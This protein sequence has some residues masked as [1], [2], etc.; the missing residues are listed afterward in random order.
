M[1]TTH[2]TALLALGLTGCLDGKPDTGADSG[3]QTTD[4]GSGD[5]SDDGEGDESGDPISGVAGSLSSTWQ[6]EWD[7]R[8]SQCAGC[9]LPWDAELT[10]NFR[11]TCDFGEDTSGVLELTAGTVYFNGDYWGAATNSDG[12]VSWST[13]GIVYGAGGLNYTYFGYITY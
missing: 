1:K 4:V 12:Q 5:G 8:G 9:D 6:L 2:L 10:R 7:V 11:T 3:P 13:A